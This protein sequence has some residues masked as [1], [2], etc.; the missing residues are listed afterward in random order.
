MATILNKSPLGSMFGGFITSLDYNFQTGSE[1]ST[2]TMVVYNK[3]GQ[4]QA[5]ILNSDL[6]LPIFGIR[7]RVVEFGIVD[8]S[9]RKILQIELEESS[10]KQLDNN[11]ILLRGIHSTGLINDEIN[12]DNYSVYSYSAVSD[13]ATSIVVSRKPDFKKATTLNGPRRI[14]DGVW[15]LGRIRASYSPTS[16]TA[17]N[18]GNNIWNPGEPPIWAKFEQRS[19]NSSISKWPAINVDDVEKNIKE[20]G[21]VGLEYGYSLRDLKSFINS[22]GI[23]VFDNGAMDDDT[24]LFQETGRLRSCLSSVLSKIG[25]AFYINPFTGSIV[26]IS[27]ADIQK[28][29]NNVQSFFNNSSIEG[30]EQTSLVKSIKGVSCVHAITKGTIN[31]LPNGSSSSANFEKKRLRRALFFKLPADSLIDK[32][33]RDRKNKQLIA[34]LIYLKIL[35]LSDDVIDKFLFGLAQKE[36]TTSWGDLYNDQMIETATFER[37]P[38]STNWDLEDN[39][40]PTLNGFDTSRTIG[41]YPLEKASGGKAESASASGLLEI[42]DNIA[43]L[44][45]GVYISNSASESRISKRNFVSTEYSFLYAKQDEYISN[46]PELSFLQTSIQQAGGD[47]NLKVSD[48]ASISGAVSRQN[49][50]HVIAFKNLWRGASGKQGIDNI[51]DNVNKS[52]LIL[53]ISENG[54]EGLYLLVNSQFAQTI[55]GLS[56]LCIDKFNEEKKNTR[57]KVTLRYQ[58]DDS[59]DQNSSFDD[60]QNGDSD[61]S[62]QIYSLRHYPGSSVNFASRDLKF[63]QGPYNEIEILRENLTNINPNISGPMI[64]S[65]ITYYR[66]PKRSDL[67]IDNGVE[68]I[69][70]SMGENGV[71]TRIRYSSK[72]F[73]SYEDSV[74]VD[75]LGAKFNSTDPRQSEILK[76]KAQASAFIRN[77]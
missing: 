1:S 13:N 53:E 65:E 48:L 11:L 2:A 68:S 18:Q 76:R 61:E 19:Y 21:G 14:S 74:L 39:N 12:S 33:A 41:A 69:S 60:E 38:S 62:P 5:P 17:W 7:M 31:E 57:K 32:I 34:R 71:S 16:Q 75:Y 73:L 63:I 44:W 25:K 77:R 4:Y 22:L 3:T 10:A 49:E 35:N 23:S 9:T 47:E 45:S 43:R 30:A 52:S 56:K 51:T 28:I 37:E 59:S 64:S 50:Y 66:P 58:V 72:K 26:V 70:V 55:N 67:D 29:N 54:N 15:L 20:D 42:V 36:D 46:I 6:I 8:D 40:Y 24:I 27:N